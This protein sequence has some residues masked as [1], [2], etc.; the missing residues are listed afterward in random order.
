MQC[1][2]EVMIRDGIVLNIT[3]PDA[4]CNSSGILTMEEVSYQKK[5]K[6]SLYLLYYAKACNEFVVPISAS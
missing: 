1:Y 4:E 2:V 3:C 6:L 5:P